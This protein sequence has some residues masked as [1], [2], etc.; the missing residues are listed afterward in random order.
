MRIFFSKRM[1]Y[2][3]RRTMGS[4]DWSPPTDYKFDDYRCLVRFLDRGQAGRG[5]YWASTVNGLGREWSPGVYRLLLS[6]ASATCSSKQ[7]YRGEITTQHRPMPPANTRKAIM[8][9]VT[10]IA[11]LGGVSAIDQLAA[12]AETV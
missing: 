10:R 8:K 12:C 6:L 4:F 2:Y 7:L 5:V 9:R 11:T 3:L 1:C